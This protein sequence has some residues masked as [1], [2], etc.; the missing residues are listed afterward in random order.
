MSAPLYLDPV[1][2]GDIR[3]MVGLGPDDTT[4]LPNET[5]E[6][7]VFL[8]T[9]E[10]TLRPF[11]EE[12]E[13]VMAALDED[14]VLDVAENVR[15]AITYLTAA[16]IADYQQRAASGNQIAS[17]QVGPIQVSYRF[18]PDWG[19]IAGECRAE[20]VRLLAGVCEAAADAFSGP[21]FDSGMTLVALAGPTRR[22]AR[23]GRPGVC[24]QV[25]DIVPRLLGGT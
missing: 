18:A 13:V 9:V 6:R 15:T 17:E 19:V 8:P 1:D 20:G 3:I 21:A 11:L 12:C 22:E 5:I 24:E 10:R 23:E 25:R 14:Y 7:R 4:A 16:R 2:Y